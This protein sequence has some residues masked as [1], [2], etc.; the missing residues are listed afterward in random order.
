[1]DPGINVGLG[2]K[3]T[4]EPVERPEQVVLLLIVEKVTLVK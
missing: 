3:N 1:V 2:A 4:D